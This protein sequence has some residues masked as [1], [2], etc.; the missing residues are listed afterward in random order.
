MTSMNLGSSHIACPTAPVTPRLHP[1]RERKRRKTFPKLRTTKKTTTKSPFHPHQLLPL[2]SH[3]ELARIT[4]MIKKLSSPQR[5]L[6]LL[7]VNPPL[8]RHQHE[9]PNDISSLSHQHPRPRPRHKY[10][11]SRLPLPPDLSRLLEPSSSF[12]VLC[13]RQMFLAL[14]NVP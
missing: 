8:H 12:K 10:H 6:L 2:L 11:P 1:Q 9:S 4:S 5:S 7:L 14:Q 13:I 3:Q